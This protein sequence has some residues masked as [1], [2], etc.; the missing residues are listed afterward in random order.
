[1]KVKSVVI[2]SNICIHPY[3]VLTLLE[4]YAPTF[5]CVCVI[6]HYPLRYESLLHYHTYLLILLIL[7]HYTEISNMK[8]IVCQP[9]TQDQDS[10]SKH[11]V[12]NIILKQSQ[13]RQRSK[14]NI[15]QVSRPE[16]YPINI[17]KVKKQKN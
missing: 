3:S 1:M 12:Q 8:D 14:H 11:T 5:V 2:R 16:D 10:S 4:H 7:L 13:E 6:I 17:A 9:Q 15:H